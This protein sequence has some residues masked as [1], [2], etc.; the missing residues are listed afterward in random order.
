MK[1]TP[2]DSGYSKTNTYTEKLEYV[3]PV[4][5]FKAFEETSI[6]FALLLCGG[7]LCYGGITLAHCDNYRALI[8]ILSLFIG[9]WVVF[10]AMILFIR[11][12]LV[13][14]ES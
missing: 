2:I 9:G 6:P 12:G 3:R 7:L 14:H 11:Y 1:L 8:G 4:S 13:E 10:H 5:I